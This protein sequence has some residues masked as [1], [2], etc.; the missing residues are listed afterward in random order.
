MA[1]RLIP[2]SCSQPMS[3]RHRIGLDV[4]GVGVVV[5]ICVCGVGNGGLT[6]LQEAVRSPLVSAM[7]LDG[8][9]RF[10]CVCV[11]VLLLFCA[12]RVTDGGLTCF[13]VAAHSP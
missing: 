6:C 9:G 11:C 4:L 8:M 13:Q 12:C 3:C 10:V 2:G 5:L 7:E 1:A